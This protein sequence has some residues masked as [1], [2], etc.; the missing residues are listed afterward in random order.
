MQH[1]REFYGERQA[2]LVSMHHKADIIAPVLVAQLGIHITALTTI[3]T[4][5]FG[6]FTGEIPRPDT[7]YQTAVAK[8]RAGMAHGGYQ[9]GIASEGSFFP[10]PAIPWLTVNHELVVLV[11]DIHGWVLEGWATA[12]ETTA[13]RQ[14]VRT[15]ADVHEFVRR[16]GFPEQGIVVRYQAD[17]V[18][19]VHK[20][21][22]TLEALCAVVDRAYHADTGDVWLETDLRAHRNPKRRVVIRQAAEDLWRNAQRMCARCG[23]PGM[24][25]VA[26]VP[27]L[28]CE[29]CGTPTDQPNALIHACV[30]CDYRVELPYSDAHTTAAPEFCGVCNP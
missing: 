12:R 22:D 18:A 27:G 13:A 14:Q 3:D 21:A 23:A 16:V 30:R 4:D 17:G 2:V 20:D 7:Q 9:L 26:T 11:D 5:Q 15:L 6:S 1:P 24:R 10:H 29:W 28:P 25:T 19:R 8:A